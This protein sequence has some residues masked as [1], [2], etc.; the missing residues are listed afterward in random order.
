MSHLVGSKLPAGRMQ[1]FD[2]QLK[3]RS[4]VMSAEVSLM[5]W[6][7]HDSFTYQ[8]VFQWGR[9]RQLD[10]STQPS[11]SC[12]PSG[13]SQAGQSPLG[14]RDPAGVHFSVIYNPQKASRCTYLLHSNC[15]PASAQAKPKWQQVPTVPHNT[16]WLPWLPPP[17]YLLA[18]FCCCLPPPQAPTTIRLFFVK[19]NLL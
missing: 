1:V 17:L 9:C 16:T 8:A 10:M 18:L 4:L 15:K 12:Y 13:W 14:K 11:K 19:C 3:E 6:T 7:G 5:H 2:L